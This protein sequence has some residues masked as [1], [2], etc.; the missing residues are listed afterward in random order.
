MYIPCVNPLLYVMIPMLL[1]QALQKLLE[2]PPTRSVKV[3]TVFSRFS[4]ALPLWSRF[5]HTIRARDSDQP[6]YYLSLFSFDSSSSNI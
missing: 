5:A 2:V 3:L 1:S 4:F 6:V